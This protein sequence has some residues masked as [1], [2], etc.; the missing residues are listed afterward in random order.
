MLADPSYHTPGKIDIIL[1]AEVYGEIMKS[2]ILKINKLTFQET[3]LGWLVFGKIPSDNEEKYQITSMITLAELDD[4]LR[5]FWEYDA[6]EYD[7]NQ[8]T[9]EE[10][11]C[12]EHFK[13]THTRDLLGRYT[14]KLPFKDEQSKLGNSKIRAILRLKQLEKRFVKQPELKPQYEKFLQEYLDLNHMEEVPTYQGPEEKVYYLPNHAVFKEDSTTTKL[15]VVFDASCKTTKDCK[16]AESLNDLLHK[17]P[18]LQ[19]NLA[20]IILRWRQHRIA[21]TADI[22]KMFRQIKMNK[23]D[24]NYQRI[25]WYADNGELK[26]F[27]LTTVTYGMAA[28]T[29][30][31]V[32][33]LHQLAEDEGFQFPI[34]AKALKNDL[35]V[36][37]YLGGADSVQEALILQQQLRTLLEQGGFNLRKWA[38]NNKKALKNIPDKHLEAGVIEIENE[39]GSIKTLG[40]NWVPEIDSITFKRLSFPDKPLTRRILL[41]NAASIFDPIGLLSPITIR[42]KIL[43]QQSFKTTNSWDETLNNEITSQWKTIAEQMNE[44]ENIKIPRW[45]GYRTNQIIEIHGFCD[46]SEAA[47]AAVIYARTLDSAGN[48]RTTLI[49]AKTR[50]APLKVKITI[51]KSELNAALL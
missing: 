16:Q 19:D 30:L 26:E 38:S 24:Q 15:R 12:E 39:E 42:A 22:E 3:A 27:I 33:V 31:S 50:V 9:P 10:V 14:V 4:K 49:T 37:D 1:S 6:I 7:N 23:E 45:I 20:N 2:G 8:L 18:R 11:K 21:F 41:S 32:R 17:G 34:G 44:I 46:A 47:C 13:T 43:V 40:L 35:Y 29:Y 25:L 5:T 28:S 36:D 48:I 51:P